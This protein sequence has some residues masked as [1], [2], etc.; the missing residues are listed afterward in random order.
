MNTQA[1]TPSALSAVPST[2]RIPLA[3]RALGGTLFPHLA[4]DDRH[5]ATALA[6]MGDDG[7][8]WL[9]DR[10][11]IY[12]NLVRTHIFRDQARAFVASHPEAHVVNLGCGLSDYLQWIDNGRMRMIDADLPE[13]MG[14]RRRIMP[15]THE[16]HRLS[17]VDLTAPDWWTRLVLP[18]RRD[19]APV[20]LLCEGVLM[21]LAPATVKAV[22]ATFGEHAPAGSAFCFD[23]MCWLSA[24]K[25]RYHGSVRHTEAQFLWGPR[26]TAELAGAHPRLVLQGVHRVMKDYGTAFALMETLF[27]AC[28][29]V[30]IYAVYSLTTR[31]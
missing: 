29:G 31:D 3:A 28:S 17:D 10:K 22:L 4:V 1:Q 14:I 7:Q 30:P 15:A 27:Q 16:R 6:H 2:L 21:Y 23:A 13:V 25:A 11:S 19:E 9:R 8:Q 12:G 24:G 26:R 20:F 5:A 18:A